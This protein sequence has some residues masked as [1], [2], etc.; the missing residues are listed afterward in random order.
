MIF[1]NDWTDY[2]ME[3]TGKVSHLIF[4][5]TA[6]TQQSEQRMNVIILFPYTIKNHRIHSLNRFG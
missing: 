4:Q 1:P 3:D 5:Q 6:L 2:T